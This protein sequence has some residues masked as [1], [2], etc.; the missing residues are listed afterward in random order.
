MVSP[1]AHSFLLG[2]AAAY[3]GIHVLLGLPMVAIRSV[4]VLAL[5]R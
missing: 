4:P 3:G 2:G 1:N 5:I